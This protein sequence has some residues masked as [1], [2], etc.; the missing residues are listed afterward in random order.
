[1]LKLLRLFGFVILCYFSCTVYSQEF[2]EELRKAIHVK[3]RLEARF[4]SRTSFINQT[5]VRV[6]GYKLGIQFDNKLSFGLGYNYLGSEVRRTLEVQGNSYFVR[7]RFNVVSPYL[8]YIFY[9][10]ERWEL[11][12][13]LQFGFGKSYYSNENDLGPN[14]FN[15]NFVATYEPAITFQYRFLKYFGAGMGVGY[16]LMIIPNRGVEENFTS[17]VYIFKFKLYFQDILTDIKDD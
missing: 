11:S 13:P 1:M 7:L 6:A 12:I 16:R 9:R 15:S 2:E 8:E 4:D 3:P 14:R 17:P 5:G 10:D